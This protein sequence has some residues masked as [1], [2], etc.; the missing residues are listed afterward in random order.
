MHTRRHWERTVTRNHPSSSAECC[1]TVVEVSLHRASAHRASSVRFTACS[2]LTVVLNYPP[3]CLDGCSSA[4]CF[5]PLSAV[6]D[7]AALRR[8]FLPSLRCEAPPHRHRTAQGCTSSTTGSAGPN[9]SRRADGSTRCHRGAARRRCTIPSCAPISPDTSRAPSALFAA[10]HGATFGHG[11]PAPRARTTHGYATAS[12]GVTFG[13]GDSSRWQQWHGGGPAEASAQCPCNHDGAGV[14]RCLGLA[15][16]HGGRASTHS[17]C[18]ARGLA[19]WDEAGGGSTPF[20]FGHDVGDRRA[21]AAC[22]SPSQGGGSPG[23][24]RWVRGPERQAHV[25]TCRAGPGPVGHGP[26]GRGVSDAQQVP[27]TRLVGRARACLD[28][29]GGR[30]CVALVPRTADGT[31]V[32]SSDLA[33][34]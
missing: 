8:V 25:R 32:P 9:P 13:H 5:D 19:G 7:G 23:A 31:A 12:H 4:W 29:P 28:G 24:A 10:S 34:P 11:D 14:S 18:R 17:R 3:R 20:A 2:R 26:W 27:F 16:G 22:E 1:A 30:R 33:F 15:G 6:C 21:G